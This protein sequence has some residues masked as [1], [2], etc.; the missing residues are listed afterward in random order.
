MSNLKIKL[1]QYNEA[2]PIG[3]KKTFKSIGVKIIHQHENEPDK[4]YFQRV[5]NYMSRIV[6][7]GRMLKS[8]AAIISKE[9]DCKPEDL[10]N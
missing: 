2:N 7:T 5:T 6:M 3:E 9:L 10:I 8:D 1:A 4:K